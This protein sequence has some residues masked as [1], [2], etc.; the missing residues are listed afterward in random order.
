MGAGVTILFPAERQKRLLNEERQLTRR[1]GSANAK[2]I[3]QRLYDLMAA[4]TLKDMATLPGRCEE[5]CGDRKGQLSLRL[6]AGF[7]LIFEPA[8]EPVPVKPD[9][10]LDWAAVTAVRV[11]EVV[12][13]HD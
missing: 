3:A 1:Y 8:H 13:Y 2:L 6:Q 5:L 7:R 11:L 4:P 10:G 12:D 9:G